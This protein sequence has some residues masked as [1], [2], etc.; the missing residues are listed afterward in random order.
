MKIAAATMVFNERIFLPIWL[1]HYGAQLGYE[2]LFIIDDGSTDGSTSDKR[3]VNLVKKNRN[4][5]D[6][7]DRVNLVSSFHEKLLDYYDIVIY[8]DSDEII[9]VDPIVQMSLR[10]YLVMSDFTYKTVTGLNV[11]AKF[12]DGRQLKTALV[13]LL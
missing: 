6:E 11:L 13:L 4:L 12:T 2:N 8:T 5:L 3:I 7:N 1:D 9:V 10:D